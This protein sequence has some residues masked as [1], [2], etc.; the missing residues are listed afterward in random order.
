MLFVAGVLL[1]VNLFRDGVHPLEYLAALAVFLSFGH[2]QIAD[3]LA[4]KEE[5][6]TIPEV[7]CYKKLWYYF[8]GKEICWFLFFILSHAYSA[9]AGVF[10][11]L[12]YPFWR[13]FYRTYIKPL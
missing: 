10:I 8:I 5:N 1:A 3:R 9:L 12:A 2:A 13:K 7:E 11:F 4:E 6:K